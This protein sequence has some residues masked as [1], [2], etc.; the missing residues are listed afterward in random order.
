MNRSLSRGKPRLIPWFLLTC[1]TLFAVTGAAQIV[2][3]MYRPQGVG[4][5]TRTAQQWMTE[6]PVSLRD[7]KCVGDGVADDTTCIQS[8]FNELFRRQGGTLYVP[9]GRY[10]FTTNIAPQIF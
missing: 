7:Y 1:A 3:P 9:R 4:G 2:D 8:A 6:R 5:E 10:R